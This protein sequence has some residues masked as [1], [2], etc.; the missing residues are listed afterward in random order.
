MYNNDYFEAFM[1]GRYQP[2][3]SVR[4]N[5]AGYE[6]YFQAPNGKTYSHVDSDQ[7]EAF[8]RC[9]DKVVEGIRSGDFTPF[10]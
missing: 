10:G 5:E 2:M 9:Q 4:R 7:S 8:R 3:I 6:A 1:E